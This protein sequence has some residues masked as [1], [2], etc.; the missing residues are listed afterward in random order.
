MLRATIAVLETNDIVFVERAECNFE[1]RGALRPPGDA[2][3]AAAW[4]EEITARVCLVI[5]AVDVNYSGT[6]EYAPELVSVLVA[7]QAYGVARVHRDYLH[8]RRLIMRELLEI[9]PWTGFDVVMR[10]TFHF[11][12]FSI[13]T[14]IV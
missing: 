3:D 14:G 7:L 1:E 8:G 11:V 4:T 10:Q 5:D 9:S 2:M 12:S 6:F 13:R